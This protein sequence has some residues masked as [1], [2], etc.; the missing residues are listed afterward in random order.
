MVR[1]RA[2]EGLTERGRY[3]QSLQAEQAASGLSQKAFCQQRGL[4]LATFTWWKDRV[5]W[6]L[7]RSRPGPKV[8]PKVRFR[9]VPSP[10]HR[11][12]A[13]PYEVLLPTGRTIRVPAGF[14]PADL[15]RLV[16]VLEAAC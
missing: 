5:R 1:G 4:N 12:P 13:V 6:M 9:E 7:T 8:R 2:S 14:D 15:R 16:A 3:W 11:P 10:T